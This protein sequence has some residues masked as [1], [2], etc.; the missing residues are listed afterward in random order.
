M[1]SQVGQ[2]RQ[3]KAPSS[4]HLGEQLKEL[5]EENARLVERAMRADA[6]Q[7]QLAEA[8]KQVWFH[9]VLFWE[10]LVNSGVF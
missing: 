4:M 6:L 7:Q 8:E 2:F 10:T 9:T 5:R 1:F 3:L